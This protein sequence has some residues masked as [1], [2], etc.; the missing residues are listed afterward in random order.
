MFSIK[1]ILPKSTFFKQRPLKYNFNWPREEKNNQSLKYTTLYTIQYSYDF[2]FCFF[3][4]LIQFII[5]ISVYNTL[6]FNYIFPLNH[7][8]KK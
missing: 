2:I 6:N 4:F 7:K 1:I 3:F 5:H 8:K